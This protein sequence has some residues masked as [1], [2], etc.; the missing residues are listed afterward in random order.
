MFTLSG[1]T[2]GEKIYNGNK[3]I[4]CRGIRNRDNLP[5][6]FK[7]PATEYPSSLEIEKLKFEYDIYQKIHSRGINKIYE[8][9][10]YRNSPVLIME[11]M[12]GESLKKIIKT[13]V[14][15]LQKSLKIAVKL[16]DTLGEIHQSHI[17][18]KDINPN[19]IVINL[20]AGELRIIDFG[21]S[22]AL[23]KEN[24]R[25]VNIPAVEGSFPYISPEQTGR[26][27]R[28]LDYRTDLYSLGVTYYEMLSGVL[29]FASGDSLE[30]VYRQ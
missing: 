22:T 16:A 27:N 3:N 7:L 29:P 20:A 10:N 30:L 13:G 2:V 12:G 14:L 1:Y 26:M 28:A 8:M 9:E 25:D 11:D 21:N 23:S 15:D 19:N 17:I 24:L 6:I 5:V 18:H 4:I